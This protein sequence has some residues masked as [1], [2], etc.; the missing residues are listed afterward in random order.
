MSR[1]DWPEGAWSTSQKSLLR[2]CPKA[3]KLRYQHGIVPKA[4]PSEALLIGTGFHRVRELVT[5]EVLRGN[6]TDEDVWQSAIETAR[7]ECPDGPASLE[8][9]RLARAYM[10]RYGTA[11]AGYGDNLVVEGSEKVLLGGELH[12]AHGGF[13]A[14]A[15]AVL[16][17]SGGQSSGWFDDVVVNAESRRWLVETKTT[18]RTPSGTIDEIA[19]ERRIWDQ[20]LS[21]AYC[22]WKTY[23]EIP[24]VL[25][26]I[27]VK[28]KTVG[29]LRVPVV[30]TEEELL[31]W[32]AEQIEAE[33]L[34]GLSCAN[35]DACAP[36]VGFRCDYFDFCYG[37][38][39]DK[40]QLY[41]LRRGREL[42]GPEEV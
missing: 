42:S 14:I 4:T 10:K 37:T 32:E 22:G 8:I 33:Q 19:A 17:A 26:D 5:L 13:A 27:V 21:L 24:G 29:F 11:N 35:R 15:D 40:E 25:Y 31:R 34:F 16:L 18:G 23:G 20:C 7:A 1:K 39:D 36:P 30:L 6:E 38:A 28:T 12:Q 2:R 9:T 3:H 41:E